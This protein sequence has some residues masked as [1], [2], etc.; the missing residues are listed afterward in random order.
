MLT[1]KKL[2]ILAGILISLL[3]AGLYIY[4]AFSQ[5]RTQMTIELRTQS[6]IKDFST[7]QVNNPDE[8]N[9]RIKSY[10]SSRYLSEFMAKYSLPDA[11][12]LNN[13]E[14]NNYSEYLLGTI[15]KVLIKK[16]V[17]EVNISYTVSMLDAPNL[18]QPKDISYTALIRFIKEGKNYYVDN[19]SFD[20]S[21]GR[22]D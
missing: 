18:S 2:Y 22:V 20:P 12:Y 3:V 4:Q 10:I 1:N 14:R 6:F 9:Q 15:N 8:Y 13:E 5:S 16:E 11:K 21:G 7:Y 19:F 17:I